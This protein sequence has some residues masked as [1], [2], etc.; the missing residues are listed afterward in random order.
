[1]GRSTHRQT[2]QLA[3]PPVYEPIPMSRKPGL[4][5]HERVREM[6]WCLNDAAMKLTD[7]PVPDVFGGLRA[8]PGQN[9]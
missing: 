4:F 9:G 6:V 5:I 1:M 2:C 8:H 3:G 7:Y